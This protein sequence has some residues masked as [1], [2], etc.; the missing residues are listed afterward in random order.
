VIGVGLLVWS[1]QA[2]PDHQR[3]SAAPV[4]SG[5]QPGGRDRLGKHGGRGRCVRPC[6]AAMAEA[7]RPRLNRHLR[8]SG[9]T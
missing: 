8:R 1:V 4:G 9:T 5:Y 6:F 3:C 7:D 2:T